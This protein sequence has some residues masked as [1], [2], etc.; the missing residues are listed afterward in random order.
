MERGDYAT[1]SMGR[2]ARSAAA[3]RMII[4]ALVCMA[5]GPRLSW[6]QSSWPGYP[7][8]TAISVT[9]AGNVGIGTANPQANLE[10]S[11]DT[12]WPNLLVSGHNG[13][14]PFINL[15]Q[16]AGTHDSPS[17]IGNYNGLGMILFRGYYGGAYRDAALISA[18]SDCCVGSGS[19][20]GQ[21][22]FWTVPNGGNT[23]EERMRITASGNVGIG[24]AV[25]YYKLAVNGTIGA[26]D[27]IVT[28]SNWSD[29]VFQSGYRLRPLSEVQA[30]IQ[31]HGH[32]PE[33]PS[34]AEVRA[35][36]VSV[37][38]MQAK[39][40]AKI[41]ELTLHLIRQEKENRELRDR[42]AQLENRVAGGG[43]TAR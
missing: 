5:A 28:N 17:N 11:S 30:Y 22:L 24:T 43:G 16:S 23:L 33:I 4:L 12:T 32:L 8:N 2:R 29:H 34:G 40:L 14:V 6:T 13:Y 36:G 15:F 31:K 25:P 3:R 20:P 9:G 21:I 38:E 35:N 39:L 18:Y 10:I 7:N 1:R 27:V 26:K 41:E 37:G 19:M 42:L